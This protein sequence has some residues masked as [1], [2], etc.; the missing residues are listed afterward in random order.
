MHLSLRERIV[1][2]VCFVVAWGL[3]L[4]PSANAAEVHWNAPAECS[5][6]EFTTRLELVLGHK[7]SQV[8]NRQ[9]NVEVTQRTASDWTLAFSWL[10]LEGKE[11]GRRE[12][13]GTGCADVTRAGS[14]AAAM[15]LQADEA[16]E[17]TPQDGPATDVAPIGVQ[18]QPAIPAARS[19]AKE[20][21]SDA[22]RG[23]TVRQPG[24][25]QA[26]SPWLAQLAVLGD[27]GTLGSAAL[28]AAL[29][30]GVHWEQLA[31]GVGGVVFPAANREAQP[32]RGGDF[33]LFAGQAWFCVRPA[34]EQWVPIGCAN[35]EIGALSGRGAG[36]DVNRKW[37][38]SALWH[39]LRPELGLA[40]PLGWD[41]EFDLRLGVSIA[42]TRPD[43]VLDGELSILRPQRF[44]PRAALGL[45]WAP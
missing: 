4:P 15:A 14:V 26:D 10:D 29:N 31:L 13:H 8:T 25:E 33:T 45:T 44:S 34:G 17:E 39:A 3:V 5:V 18:A 11:S 28:G 7:L 22:N 12:L 38:R 36:A 19:V 23:A 42:L 40:V 41:L 27:T 37:S 32:G 1:A 21:V 24:E 2:F 20:R 16:S 30:G 43:F 9:L 6:H 35:Y